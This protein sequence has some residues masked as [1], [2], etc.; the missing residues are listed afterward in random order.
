MHFLLEPH[1]AT[2]QKTA[3]FRDTAAETTNLTYQYRAGLCS[4]DVMCFLLSTDWGF[5]FQKT[6]LICI[7][8]EF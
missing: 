7:S 3:F 1:G 5:V 4:G 8:L 2:S 6:A